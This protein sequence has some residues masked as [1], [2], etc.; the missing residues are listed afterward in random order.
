MR[1]IEFNKAKDQDCKVACSKCKAKVWHKVITSVDETGK[2][3]TPPQQGNG[4]TLEDA[5]V[6]SPRA[7]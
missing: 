2:E 6:P 5:Q 4:Q 1:K 3:D 7:A